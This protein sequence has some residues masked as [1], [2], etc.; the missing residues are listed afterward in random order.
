M[1]VCVRGVG[2][3]EHGAGKFEIFVND[4]KRKYEKVD[5]S[6]FKIGENY[7]RMR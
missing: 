2:I 4:W 6:F 1:L 5:E 3:F 7:C